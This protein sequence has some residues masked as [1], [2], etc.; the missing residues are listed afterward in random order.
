MNVQEMIDMLSKVQDKSQQVTLHIE[1]GRSLSICDD[2]DMCSDEQG[3]YL[4]GDE[5]DYQ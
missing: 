4:S 1:H 3:V 2:F 5:T